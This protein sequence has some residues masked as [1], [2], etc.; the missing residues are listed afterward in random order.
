MGLIVYIVSDFLHIL[1]F[2]IVCDRI[3]MLKRNENKYHDYSIIICLTILFSFFI[4]YTREINVEIAIFAYLIFVCVSLN[5]IYAEKRQKICLISIWLMFLVTMF[6]MMSTVLI[7]LILSI[8]NVEYPYL[9]KILVQLVTVGFAAIVG[10]VLGKKNGRGIYGVSNMYLVCFTLLTAVNSFVLSVLEKIILSSIYVNKKMILGLALII[11]VLGAFFQMAMLLI[12]IVSRD[13]HKEKELLMEKYLNEQ[14]EHYEYLELREQET[15]KFRHDIRSHIYVLRSLYENQEYDK[16]DEYLEKINGRIDAFGNKIS[17]NNSIVDAVLNKYLVEAEQKRVHLDVKGHFP[18]E[19]SI[20]AF[21]LCTIVSNLLSNAIEA[22]HRCGG[23][24]VQIAFRY[25]EREIM[26]S[27]ENDYDGVILYEE[28]VMKTRKDDRNS[29]G[30]G[31]ESIEECLKRNG[32][33][34]DIQ[35]ENFKFKTMLL[36]RDSNEEAV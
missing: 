15:R 26:I 17:V 30:F 4:Y 36:L 12:L 20:S 9:S 25:N 6:D 28:G 8:I 33:Y 22:A 24:L 29:H 18:T 2:L 16:F 34:M 23:K 32:G 35:T 13:L 3:L 31:L 27:V 19:C 11:I 10:T 7:D 14:I 5:I 21:D 1:K